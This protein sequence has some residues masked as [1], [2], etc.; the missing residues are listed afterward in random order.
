MGKLLVLDLPDRQMKFDA[1]TSF[2]RERCYSWY[3]GRESIF[4]QWT[5]MANFGTRGVAP[6]MYRLAFKARSA[7]RSEVARALR[8]ARLLVRHR[9]R[10]LAEGC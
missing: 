1:R 6:T 5:L 7:D 10:A 2:G 8:Y 3:Q 9:A 4:M